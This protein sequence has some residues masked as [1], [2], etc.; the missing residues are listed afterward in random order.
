MMEAIMDRIKTRSKSLM[1]YGVVEILHLKPN[2]EIEVLQLRVSAID[3]K[4][5]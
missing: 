2:G 3:P 4:K 5:N 1:K